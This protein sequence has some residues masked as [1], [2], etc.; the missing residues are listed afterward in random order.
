MADRSTSANGLDGRTVIVTG[1]GHGLGRFYA[2]GCAAAGAN[3]VVADLDQA[4]AEA[5]VA[6][7]SERGGTGLAVR[8]DVTD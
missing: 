1:A 5:V 7:V 3:V 2:L 8:A 4:A 6:E